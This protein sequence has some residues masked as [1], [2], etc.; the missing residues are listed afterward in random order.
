MTDSDRTNRSK[1]SCLIK[2][3]G[4]NGVGEELEHHWTRSGNHSS[5]RDLADYFHRQ[6]LE[7]SYKTGDV[8]LVDSEINSLYRLLTSDGVIRD[9]YR[10]A[11]NR[12]NQRRLI[13]TSFKMI[14]SPL[15]PYLSQTVSL[16]YAPKSTPHARS[17]RH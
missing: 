4:L 12:L 13:C 17:T 1:V 16:C 7:N 6:S 8:E 2:R 10:Q 15:S 3:H 9:A 11:L 14:L 5:L